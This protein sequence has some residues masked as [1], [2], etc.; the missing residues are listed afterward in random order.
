MSPRL[1]LW[2]KVALYALGLTVLIYFAQW[3]HLLNLI[4]ID[5]A[6]ERQFLTLS[7]HTVDRAAIDKLRVIYIDEKNNGPLGAFDD[8]ISRQKWRAQHAKLLVALENA[9]ASVVAFDITFGPSVSDYLAETQDFARTIAAVRERGKTRVLIGYGSDPDVDHDILQAMPCEDMGLVQIARQPRDTDGKHALTSALVADASV[10]RTADTDNALLRR[11]LPMGLAM[12][13]AART[14]AGEIVEP[15]IDAGRRQ[16]VFFGNAKDLRPITVDVRDVAG[17]PS[18]CAADGAQFA[19]RRL[20]LL[21]V[22]MGDGSPFIERSYASV[23]LQ[24]QLSE[25]YQGKV[26]LIGARVAED[27][28]AVGPETGGGTVWGYQVHAR[29]LADLWSE[30]YLRHVDEHWVFLT[31]FLLLVIGVAAGLALPKTEINTNVPWIGSTPIPLGLLLVAGIHAFILIQL[32]RYRYVL[33]DIGYQWLALIAGYYV[34]SRPFKRKTS[35][36]AS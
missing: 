6:L 14:S 8:P 21:P 35:G 31:L 15:G 30:T 3:V 20:A 1:R 16:V 29:V 24:P 19:T 10:Q 36:V 4:G 22:W 9:G 18:N 32:L 7:S 23:V 5:T 17:A 33:Y 28:V 11:P 25:D 27:L 2:R 12:L 26:V 13:L 34:V